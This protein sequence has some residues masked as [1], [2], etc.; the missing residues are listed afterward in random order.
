[1]NQRHLL[2]IQMFVAVVFAATNLKAQHECDLSIVSI[3]YGQAILPNTL[4]GECKPENI[5]NVEVF[6]SD[7]MSD[8]LRIN[9]KSIA[10]T[11][12]PQS[13][14]I[15][16]IPQ[17]LFVELVGT[18]CYRFEDVSLFGLPPAP[19]MIAGDTV[20]CADETLP[21]I[22]LSG[23]AN[24]TFHWTNNISIHRRHGDSTASY[25]YSGRASGRH[26]R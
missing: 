12:S 9:G 13:I 23:H 26:C 1:M 18:E 3:E 2:F 7:D 11:G 17:V 19:E 8:T 22:T 25:Q 15:I 14:E 5:L 4:A 10:I 21:P 16:G 20:F 6:Y 24:S